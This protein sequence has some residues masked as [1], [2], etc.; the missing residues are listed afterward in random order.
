MVHVKFST[1]MPEC[2]HPMQAQE[3]SVSC[4]AIGGEGC[5]NGDG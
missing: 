3:R 4:L 2:L 5:L 1:L